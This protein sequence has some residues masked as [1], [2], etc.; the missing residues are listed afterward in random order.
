MTVQ[1]GSEQLKPRR[2]RELDPIGCKRT[3]SPENAV[4]YS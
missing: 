3:G 1:G 2:K 4:Y